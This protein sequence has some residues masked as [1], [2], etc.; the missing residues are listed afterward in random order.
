MT[1]DIIFPEFDK[2]QGNRSV[3]AA[4][5]APVTGGSGGTLSLAALNAT[6]NA[7]NISCF[8]YGGGMVTG[9]QARGQAPPRVC[10][11]TQREQ[12]GRTTYTVADLQYGYK[13][14]EDATHES[15]KAK[16][17]LVKDLDIEIVERL[18]KPAKLEELVVGDVVNVYPVSLGHQN[19]SMTGDETDEFAEYSIT[20]AAVLRADPI[21]DVSIV[22]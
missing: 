18:G 11:T 9:E 14:Q 1:V 2:A 10:D 19:R 15:N 6:N 8:I 20:Q 12:L 16:A 7:L 22:A 13:P 21:Y 17:M 4:L 5:D 3:V